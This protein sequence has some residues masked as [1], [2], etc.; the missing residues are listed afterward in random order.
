MNRD[1]MGAKPLAS[2]LLA[3]VALVGFA[4][5]GCSDMRSESNVEQGSAVGS[6]TEEADV[7]RRMEERQRRGNG[8]GGGGY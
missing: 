1:V 5:V 4:V 2:C 7:I 6:P 3:V 8:G